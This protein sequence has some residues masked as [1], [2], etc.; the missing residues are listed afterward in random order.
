[1]KQQQKNKSTYE[2]GGYNKSKKKS[3]NMKTGGVRT[4]DFAITK[5][6]S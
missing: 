4:M 5:P 1:M 3:I 2:N 6:V